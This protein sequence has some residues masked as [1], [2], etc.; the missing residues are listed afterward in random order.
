ML[1]LRAVYGGSAALSYTGKRFAADRTVFAGLTVGIQLKDIFPG[2]AIQLPVV[3]KGGAAG[4]DAFEQYDLDFGNEFFCFSF[5]YITSFPQ[6]RQAGVEQGF[7]C[8]N[9][10]HPG[11]NIVIHNKLFKRDLPLLSTFAEVL[12]IKV[13]AQRLHPQLVKFGR[14]GTGTWQLYKFKQAE[15]A[16]ALK[17]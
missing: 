2:G 8:V 7:G 15:P 16:W 14:R 17:A 3:G 6:G 5:C 12:G 11:N 1:A 10:P 4:S 13:V 9:I